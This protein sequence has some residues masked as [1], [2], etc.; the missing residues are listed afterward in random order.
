MLF[1]VAHLVWYLSQFMVLT[2]ATSST[3]APPRASPSGCRPSYL[4]AGD[5]VEL[6]IEGLGRARQP[7]WPPGRATPWP[8]SPDWWP[9]V[10][11]GASGIGPGRRAGADERAG[12]GHGARLNWTTS[13]RTHR[14]ARDVADRASR[15]AATMRAV[16]R[17]AFGGLDILVNNAGIGAAGTVEDNDDD[18]G[19]ARSTSTSSASPGLGRGAAAPAARRGGDRQHL[20]RRRAQRPTPACAYKASKGAVLALTFAMATDHV[21]D[22]IRVNCRAPGHHT[23]WVDRMLRGPRTRL[24]NGRPSRPASPPAGWSPRGD[25]ARGRLPRQPALAGSTTG[26]A[27]DV[28]GGVTHLRTRPERG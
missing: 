11:G 15:G 14:G 16:A 3:P 20:L 12:E 2:R 23:P 18:D 19:A 21:P 4:R 28:D 7:S 24:R 25:V 6:E 9:L 13:R 5:V 22:E 17:A 8:T 27:L 1:P 26:T 10:T